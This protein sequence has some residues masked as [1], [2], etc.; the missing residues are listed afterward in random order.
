MGKLDS[1]TFI[2]NRGDFDAIFTAEYNTATPPAGTEILRPA[3]G[4]QLQIVGIEVHSAATSG[5]VAFKLPT[6]NDTLAKFYM[7]AGN[8]NHES[9]VY[10]VGATDEP[11]T[12]INT[13]AS[14][15]FVTIRYKQF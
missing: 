7:S 4:K 6:T 11:L 1:S 12:M 8:P 2:A 14:A 9:K 13:I 10:A 3:E 15:F 5:T